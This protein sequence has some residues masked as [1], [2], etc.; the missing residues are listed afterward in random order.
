MTIPEI[1]RGV[2]A[3]ELILAEHPRYRQM[4][5]D[6]LLSM[7]AMVKHSEGPELEAY[8]MEFNAGMEFWEMY[9]GTSDE[10]IEELVAQA[11]PPTFKHHSVSEGEF[12]D[13]FT[14]A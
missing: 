6:W 12:K 7:A 13:E 9:A 10:E 4:V 1:K 14:N 5:K 3:G 11:K 8:A 2:I